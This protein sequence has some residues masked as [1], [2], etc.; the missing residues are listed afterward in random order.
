MWEGS[1]TEG[2]RIPKQVGLGYIR[3]LDEHE[4][5]TKPE[6]KARNNV[7]PWFLPY[8]IL[9]FGFFQDRVSLYSPGCPG[10]HF[11][12]RLVSNSE[13]CLPLPP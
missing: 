11:V 7:R 9:L 1:S 5:V 6:G 3:E 8:F 4:T 10:T 12:T 2:G 13:I